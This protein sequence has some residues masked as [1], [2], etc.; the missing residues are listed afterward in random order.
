MWV[1]LW[2]GQWV[3]PVGKLLDIT[4]KTHIIFLSRYYMKHVCSAHPDLNAE[5][6]SRRLVCLPQGPQSFGTKCLD[7]ET[8]G[9]SRFCRFVS[10]PNLVGSGIYWLTKLYVGVLASRAGTA[11]SWSSGVWIYTYLV[12]VASHLP[13]IQIS[14]S[15]RPTVAAVVAAPI[16]K[17]CVE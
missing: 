14:Q 16:W 17:L 12:G 13:S 5:F 1:W 8:Q 15:G 4:P 10:C 9:A 3:W 11:W 7:V 6:A 2:V